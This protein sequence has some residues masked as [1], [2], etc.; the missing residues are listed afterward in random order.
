MKLIERIGNSI[1]TVKNNVKKAIEETTVQDVAC[2]GVSCGAALAVICGW[3]AA[4]IND[5]SKTVK[6][7]DGKIKRL[8]DLS[9]VNDCKAYNNN[10]VTHYAVEA[11][12]NT[13]KGTHP[14]V[15]AAVDE[16][17]R[18]AQMDFIDY[19]GMV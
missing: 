15:T 14:G 5:L 4:Q 11:V 16:A 19:S 12:I 18:N 6:A 9:Y 8:A 13:I 17:I 7:M 3:Q 1:K 10:L 2:I